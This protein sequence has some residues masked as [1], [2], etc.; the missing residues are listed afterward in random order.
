VCKSR[1]FPDCN[2]GKPAS[3]RSME[4]VGPVTYRRDFDF[5]GYLPCIQ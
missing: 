3:E 4:P 1:D 5:I 2:C